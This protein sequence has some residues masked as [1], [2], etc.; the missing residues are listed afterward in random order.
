MITV[1]DVS[2]RQGRK[3]YSMSGFLNSSEADQYISLLQGRFIKGSFEYW[4][5][6]QES[7]IRESWVKIKE[8]TI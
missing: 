2:K 1:V 4:Q 3:K 6:T 5:N 8:V 7:R